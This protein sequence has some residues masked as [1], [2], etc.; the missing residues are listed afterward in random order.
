MNTFQ[1]KKELE[2]GIELLDSQHKTFIM[3]ANKFI[4]KLGFK[5]GNNG[6]KEELEYLR[7]YLLYH[8]QVE[9]TF[10]FE[11]NYPYYLDHQAEHKHLAFR[12]KQMAS[13]LNSENFSEESVLEFYK[14]IEEWVVKHILTYDLE[15]SKFYKENN[16]LSDNTN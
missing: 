4:I 3:N 9:E 12:V 6:A 5:N 7:D 1:W 13:V 15:F 2:T 16:D 11:S 14:F 8:F 10:Q